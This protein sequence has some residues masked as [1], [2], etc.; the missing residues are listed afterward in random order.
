[1]QSWWTRGFFHKH[2]KNQTNANF[3][4]GA[5]RGFTKQ[6]LRCLKWRGCCRF[7]L[8]GL[9]QKI[10]V[11]LRPHGFYSFSQLLWLNSQIIFSFIETIISDHWTIRFLF[12]S[13]W[14]FLLIWAN[15]KCF[16]TCVQKSK[17]NCLQFAQQLIAYGLLF[18]TDEL[19]LT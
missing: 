15:C 7:M 11:C 19:I 9:N 6:L 12:T 2:K 10:P 18:K 14:N 4:T 16:G 3:W 17:S 1:M 13:D 8:G 5:Q